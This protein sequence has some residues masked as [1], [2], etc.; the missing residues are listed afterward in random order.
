MVGATHHSVHGDQLITTLQSAVPIG[1]AARNDARYVDGAVLLLA[2]HHVEAEALLRLGQLND[3]RMCVSL[4]GRERRH[5]RLCH[6]IGANIGRGGRAAVANLDRLVDVLVHLAHAV[7]EVRLQAL[8]QLRQLRR[9]EFA[10]L[11]QPVDQFDG[12]AYVCHS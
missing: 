11:L 9:D 4:G 1:D 10:G 5:S 2:A 12:T 7:E 8:V 3:S 6:G